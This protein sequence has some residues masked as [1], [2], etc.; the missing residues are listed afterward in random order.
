M[1]ETETL[2]TFRQRV[3]AGAAYLDGVLPGWWE[4]I[5][6][7]TLNLGSNCRCVLG[8]LAVDIAWDT[9]D[10][11]LLRAARADGFNCWVS[12]HLA[13]LP[14]I[15]F[16]ESERMGFD[17]SDSECIEAEDE[18]YGALTAEWRNLITERRSA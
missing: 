6:L 17:L 16:K 4:K 2:P 13:P 15:G 14:A 7:E 1:S 11:Q 9:R 18:L 8:Q 10:F 12:K 5:D 3:E